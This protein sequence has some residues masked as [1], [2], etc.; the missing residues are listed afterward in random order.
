MTIFSRYRQ[1]SIAFVLL[2]VMVR[3]LSGCFLFPPVN[4]PNQ[5]D[6]FTPTLEWVKS[7]F[8]P[9]MDVSPVGN[10][11]SIGDRTRSDGRIFI[12]IQTFSPEGQ[13]LDYSEDAG[14][15]KEVVANFTGIY[16]RNIV[17]HVSTNNSPNYIT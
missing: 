14:L 11:V 4:P 5:T 1:Q 9:L 6:S 3:L 16:N 17:S 7:T 10:I 2:L 15:S 12:G 8:G 13:Q